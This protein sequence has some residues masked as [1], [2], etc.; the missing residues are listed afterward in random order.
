VKRYLVLLSTMLTFL[1][2]DKSHRLDHVN[3]SH[4]HMVVLA[5]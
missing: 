2:G 3:F 4:L 1:Q 5:C